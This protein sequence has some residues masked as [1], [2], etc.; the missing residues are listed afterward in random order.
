MG[1]DINGK[2]SRNDDDAIPIE[3]S[4]EVYRRAI[5]IDSDTRKCN[6]VRMSRTGD[7]RKQKA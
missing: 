2:L 4:E 7:D 3:S 5:D 1:I 6:K